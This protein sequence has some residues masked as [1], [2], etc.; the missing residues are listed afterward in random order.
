MSTCC[1]CWIDLEVKL[2]SLKL[3]HKKLREDLSLSDH[4]ASK[5]NYEKEMKTHIRQLK[6]YNELKDISMA[7][8]QLVAD[9]K[10]VRIKDILNEIGVED[11]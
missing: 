6:N 4:E 2:Q 1:T 7:L 3:Q 11:D 9:Q 5:L 10:H 8:I